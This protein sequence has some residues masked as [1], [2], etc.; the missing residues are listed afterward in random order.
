MWALCLE[1]SKCN[2]QPK[3]V[4]EL[5]SIP[6]LQNDLDVNIRLHGSMWQNCRSTLVS[7]MSGPVFFTVCCGLFGHMTAIFTKLGSEN[8]R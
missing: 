2:V 6:N 7:H 5:F 3:A 8:Y 4:A 1:N